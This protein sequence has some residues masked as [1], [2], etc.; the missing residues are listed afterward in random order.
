MTGTK[1]SSA[2]RRIVVGLSVAILGIVALGVSATVRLTSIEDRARLITSDSMAGLS[3][4]TKIELYTYQ[5]SVL[6]Q[7]HILTNDQAEKRRIESE[8]Q[9]I[10]LI[11]ANLLEGYR[12]TPFGDIER[13]LF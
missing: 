3:Y 11:A 2:H 9:S 5:Q 8:I 1:Q 7:R 4:T 10:A 13:P 6:I 12:N